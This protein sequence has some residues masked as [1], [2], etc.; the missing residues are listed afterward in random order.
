[1]TLPTIRLCTHDTNSLYMIQTKL[2]NKNY[3]FVTKKFDDII[4]SQ[5]FSKF[6]MILTLLY[7]KRHTHQ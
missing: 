3:D 1:M 6:L 7:K 2:I 5:Y 4:S